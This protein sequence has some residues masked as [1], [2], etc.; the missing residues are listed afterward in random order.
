MEEHKFKKR[1]GW[2]LFTFFVCAAV[3]F[4]L[5]PH[6]ELVT[7]YG[8]SSQVIEPDSLAILLF[9]SGI[10]GVVLL[11]VYLIDYKQYKI[12][13]VKVYVLSHLNLSVFIF[14]VGVFNQSS[15]K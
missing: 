4:A 13:G 12:K 8:G 3:F 10:L 1:N 5:L 11:F 6:V 14:H 2:Y 7:S 15:M 9:L